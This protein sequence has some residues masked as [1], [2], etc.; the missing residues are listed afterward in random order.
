MKNIDLW[1][2]KTV[3]DERELQKMRP[4]RIIFQPTSRKSKIDTKKNLNKLES[5]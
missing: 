5:L 4:A 2:G 1:E 3:I